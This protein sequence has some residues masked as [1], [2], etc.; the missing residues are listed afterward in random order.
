M[1]V[2]RSGM[3]SLLHFE[4]YALVYFERTGYTVVCFAFSPLIGVLKSAS[5]NFV[6]HDVNSSSVFVHD[7]VTVVATVLASTV[8]LE[9]MDVASS[10]SSS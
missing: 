1:K 2:G 4:L 5:R 3:R 7:F 10:A 8:I 9:R 6:C